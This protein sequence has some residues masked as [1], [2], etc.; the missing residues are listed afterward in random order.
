MP[1]LSDMTPGLGG[2]GSVMVKDGVN[3]LLATTTEEWAD[4]LGRLIESIDAYSNS[5]FYEYDAV[6]NLV[7]QADANRN[8]TRFAFDSLNRLQRTTDA[9]YGTTEYEYERELRDS[10]GSTLFAGTSEIQRNIIAQQLDL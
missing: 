1:I 9:S 5:S 3:G 10:I 2:H 6:G 7:T 4:R 8:N